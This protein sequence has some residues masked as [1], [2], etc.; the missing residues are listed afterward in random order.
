MA[1]T[2][3]AS[4]RG[5]T[6]PYEKD[7]ARAIPALFEQFGPRTYALA[8]RITGSAA[9][10]EDVVQ[11]AFLQ[12]FRRWE[13]FEGRA[14]PGTWLYAIAARAAKRRFRKRKDGTSRRSQMKSFT[15]LLPFRDKGVVDLAI[16]RSNPADPLMR[17]EA[18]ELVEDAILGLPTPYRVP[19]VMKDILEMPLAD[20]SEALGLQVET[21]K[22]RI[23]RGR[24]ALREK[25]NRDLRTRRAPTPEYEK[26]VCLDLL[27]AKLAA[28]DSG[29][30]FTL[31]REVFCERCRSVFAELDL[32]QNACADLGREGMP[33][34]ARARV[35]EAIGA[36]TGWAD[37]AVAK[38]AR[39]PAASRA[40]PGRG[41]S[42]A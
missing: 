41:R 7:P 36:L 23:H 27:Q 25:L 2:V 18:K 14:D 10:A 3:D 16:D 1:R 6:R 34:E 29:R 32:G 15:E 12:A 38:P 24:L 22:T 21:V 33:K 42:R 17:A 13:T 28:M 4:A 30:G 39:A 35:L 20:I 37:R 26:Q 31:G 8:Y 9:E 11:E 5:A 40:R 19:I